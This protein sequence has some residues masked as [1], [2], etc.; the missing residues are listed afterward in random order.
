MKLIQGDC[1][2]K[3]KEIADNSVDLVIIDP[4]YEFVSGGNS[5]SGLGQRKK[6]QKEAIYSLDTDLTKDK[7]SKQRQE[8][9]DYVSE[10]GKDKESERLRVIAN[11]ID[12]R[13]NIYFISKGIDNSI[14]DELCR[15]MKKI[16]I[17]M[18]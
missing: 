18:V 8:Y 11:A 16:N 10:H 1:Y 7:I 9:F 14:L 12:N 5:S 17:Y 13:K 15:V 6:K 3:I 4:P 2:E